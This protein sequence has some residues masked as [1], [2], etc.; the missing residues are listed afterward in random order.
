MAHTVHEFGHMPLAVALIVLVL[1]CA[2]GHLH[3]ALAGLIWAW[4]A[5]KRRSQVA[6]W[7]PLL[8]LP[9]VSTL[10]ERYFPMIFVWNFGYTW[11]YSGLP[12]YQMAELIGFEGLSAW[13]I[14]TNLAFFIPVLKGHRHF[15]HWRLAA[16]AILMFLIANGWGAYLLHRL[17]KPD[18]EVG[19]LVIQANIGNLEKQYAEK[20]WGF[21]DHIISRYTNLTLEGLE[22]NPR[23]QIDFALWPETA[24]PDQIK[25]HN[26]SL[27]YA[28]RLISFLQGQSLALVTGSY[29]ED[30][31]QGK[32]T[33]SLF[34]FNAQGELT[35]PQYNKTLL[36]AFGEY[37]PFGEQFPIL[38]TW[39]KEVADFAR[40]SGPSLL[41]QGEVRLGAQICYE[42]LF[43]AFSKGL[44]DLGAH[45]IVNVTND[46]WYGKS[47]EPY[48]HMYMTLARAIEFRRPVVRS[49]NTGFTTAVTAGGDIM[50]RSPLHVEWHHLYRIPYLSEPPVTFFQKF[51]I[52]LVPGLLWLLFVIASGGLFY[53]V[54]LGKH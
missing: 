50:T 52:H 17:P 22:Q 26:L 18:K 34:S 25:A 40:G 45:L 16:V 47:S 4:L 54:Q 15:R 3:F 24:F 37:I 44:A 2:V 53:R 29:S 43:P 13:T 10:C 30:Q 49:T 21:R 27:G 20:G 46:S 28:R 38:K 23:E 7:I 6:S 5:G 51:G 31:K 11:M 48:Q 36:L 19:I 14:F 39:L 41:N 1:F 35:D 12:F 32:V 42:G 33:N 8:L 9:V